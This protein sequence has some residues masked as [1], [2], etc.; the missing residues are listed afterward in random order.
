M[1]LHTDLPGTRAPG[2]CLSWIYEGGFVNLWEY[3]TAET[4]KRAGL[5]TDN[6]V[7]HGWVPTGTLQSALTRFVGLTGWIV[8]SLL[9]VQKLEGGLVKN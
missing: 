9:Y 6:S 1:I 8:L 5:S 7:D 4:N 2:I 3:S